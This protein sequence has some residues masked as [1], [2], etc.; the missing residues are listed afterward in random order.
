MP[1]LARYPDGSCLPILGALRVRVIECAITISTPANRQTGVYRLA[2]TLTDHHHYPAA[3]SIT[4][5]HRRWE[6]E[7]A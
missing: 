7:I 2:T 1:I 4:L 5:C 3:E 6:I